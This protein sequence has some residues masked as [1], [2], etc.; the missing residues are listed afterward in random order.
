MHWK[1]DVLKLFSV[2]VATSL[3]VSLQLKGMLKCWD[4]VL[5]LSTLFPPWQDN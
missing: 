5:I 3:M 1:N 2:A 4:F